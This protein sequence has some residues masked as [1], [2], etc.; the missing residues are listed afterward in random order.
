MNE[1]LLTGGIA[2]FAFATIGPLLYAICNFIDKGLLEKYFKEG[3]VGTLILF[4][5]LLSGIALPVYVWIDPLMFTELT[6]ERLLLLSITGVLEVTI[7]WCYL[8]A[9]KGDSPSVVVTYYQLVPVFAYLLGIHYLGEH[10]STTKLVAAL[11]ILAGTTLISIEIDN[12]NKYSFKWRTAL[13]M[14]IASLSWAIQEVVF[15]VATLEHSVWQS[16][17]WKHVAFLVTGILIFFL[18]KSY[19]RNFVRAWRKNSRAIIMLNMI[20][21]ALF[22]S[23]SVSV[24]YAVMLAPVAIVMLLTTYQAFFALGIG[25]LLAAIFTSFALEKITRQNL[26]IRITALIITAAGTVMLLFT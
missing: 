20:N 17:F 2:W 22:T 6:A 14:G 19:R 11:I 25:M 24:A 13:F 12:E 23:A 7:L 9:L 21:E 5:S 16:L 15:K 8:A 26:T 18:V 3:G 4:S 10:L 1:T